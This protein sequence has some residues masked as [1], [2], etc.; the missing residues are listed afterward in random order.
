VIAR[1]GLRVERLPGAYATTDGNGTLFIAPPDE[2]D[3][4]D[5]LAQMIF[6]ELCHSLVEGPISLHKT[7]WGLDNET[8]RDEVR[9]HA[10]LRLQALLLR[11]LGLGGVLA[12]TTDFRAYYDALPPDPLGPVA[13][14]PLPDRSLPLARLAAQRSEEVPWAPHLGRALEATAAL[15]ETVGAHGGLDDTSLWAL[16]LPRARAHPSTPLPMP[17]PGAPA[18]S[19]RCQECAWAS[20]RGAQ[21]RCRIASRPVDADDPACERFEPALDCGDCG[22]CCREAFHTV[23]LRPRERF[24]Q[25]HRELTVLHEGKPELPRNAE[26]RCPALDGDGAPATPYRCRHHDERPRTCREFTVA[27]QNCLDARRRVGRTR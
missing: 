18:A 6:H 24:T 2:L 17:A 11:P 8:G 13:G 20:R 5:C 3:R 4:D 16:T 27:S 26:G 12:P 23:L 22:A 9:E 15:A 14:A 19:A 25:L 10:T 21:F 7:D 1:I